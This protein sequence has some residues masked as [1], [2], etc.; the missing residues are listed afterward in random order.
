[1]QEGQP[2]IFLIAFRVWVIVWFKD[3]L[4]GCMIL[5]TAILSIAIIM[6]S[7]VTEYLMP[8]SSISWV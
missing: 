8:E 2:D 1:M 6:W 5:Y 4:V 3:Y 7:V